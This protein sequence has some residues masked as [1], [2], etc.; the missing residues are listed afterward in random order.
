MRVL[1]R[2]RRRKR[3]RGCSALRPP[4]SWH[5]RTAPNRDPLHGR[6]TEPRTL[7]VFAR[8]NQPA[9]RK[10]CRSLAPSELGRWASDV[11]TCTV[12][13][14]GASQASLRLPSARSARISFALHRCSGVLTL[15]LGSL[16][17]C[18]TQEAVDA[19]FGSDRS[20]TSTGVIT[21]QPV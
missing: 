8:R 18:R 15:V 14:C 6:D 16:C 2:M 3:E 21:R 17:Q 7:R 9:A 10:L 13:V 5:L 20:R 19:P 1:D 12:L 4:T 11:V